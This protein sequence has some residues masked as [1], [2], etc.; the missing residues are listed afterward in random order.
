MLLVPVIMMMVVVVMMQCCVRHY[1][2]E[3]ALREGAALR[4]LFLAPESLCSSRQWPVI[5]SEEVNIPS[6]LISRRLIELAFLIHILH[7]G[8]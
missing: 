1:R 7:Q 3:E 5:P 6:H 4:A 2:G 8:N